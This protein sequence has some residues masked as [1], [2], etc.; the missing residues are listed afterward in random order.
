[1]RIIGYDTFIDLL[2]ATYL[3]RYVGIP[4]A[5]VIVISPPG[6]AKTTMAK[7]F[8]R[9]VGASFVRT[10]G[11]YDMLPEDF[12]A[13]K[14]IDYVDGRPTIK[15]ELR[16]VRHLL[17][18]R[19]PRPAIW[20]FD[21]FD[22]MNRK[23][24]TALLELM[25]EQQVTLPTGESYKLNFMLIAAG[26]SRKYDK[27]ANPIPRSVRDR[28]ATYWELGYLGPEREVEILNE[29]I[30]YMMGIDTEPSHQFGLNLDRKAFNAAL[31]RIKRE[32]GT[33][34]V[35]AVSYLR[36]HKEVE[37]QPGPRAYIHATLLASA[38]AVVR[39]SLSA[40]D[41]LTAFTAAVAG[42]LTVASDRT[43]F[44]LCQ[45]AFEKFCMEGRE[46]EV[47]DAREFFRRSRRERR[48]PWL[49]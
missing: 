43:P 5:H 20:F 8:A 26:N 42:K 36:R 1:M 38:M 15:W 31:E 30:N 14:T 27:D 16:A 39:G 44:E 22:K 25:E 33:C 7:L 49:T 17:A 32:Y 37:E 3:L 23:S 34:I 41:V 4:S 46:P 18:E 24:M 48:N 6:T 47:E 13:E 45:E 28:F 11:R 12:I 29:A 9:A 40:T 19:N 2:K 10:T 21:E 35:R